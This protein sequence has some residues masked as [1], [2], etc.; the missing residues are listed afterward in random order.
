MKQESFDQM[1]LDL[2]E[3]YNRIKARKIEQIEYIESILSPILPEH[4]EVKTVLDILAKWKPKAG[5]SV[6]ESS[7]IPK[8]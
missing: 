8:S 4:P 2:F 3:V 1:S 6:Y 5:Q 7:H